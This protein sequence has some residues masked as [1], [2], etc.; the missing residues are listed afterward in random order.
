MNDEARKKRK[1]VFE[2]FLRQALPK[3]IKGKLKK[4]L[5]K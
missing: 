3:G 2:N 5:S 4:I 1:R